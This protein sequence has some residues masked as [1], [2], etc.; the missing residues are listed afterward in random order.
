MSKYEKR[1]V[2]AEVTDRIIA[3]L[4]SGTVPW[5]KPWTGD[6]WQPRNLQSGR[7]YRGINAFLL[8]LAAYDDPRWT[9]FNGAKKLG[10][11]VRKGEKG[12]LVT[13]WKFLKS[14]PTPEN[15]E[16]RTIPM[17]KHFIVFNV[18]QVEW[19]EGAI[20]EY[21]PTV[22]EEFSPEDEAEATMADFLDRPDAPTLTYGGGRAYY[23]PSVHAVNLPNRDTFKSAAGFYGTAFHEFGHATG[24]MLKPKRDLGSGGFGSD[25]YAREELVAE[26]TAAFVLGTLGIDAEHKNSA[27]YI[28]GWLRAIREDQQDGGGKLVIQAA[29]QAQK[30]ADLILGTVYE[31]P[32]SDDTSEATAP[33]VV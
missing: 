26:M 6:Q 25:P 8:S 33:A 24:S 20:P 30:A 13:L 5:Q 17:L 14:K 21:D 16:G 18:A 28:K 22:P 2:Y 29:G 15:P 7:P 3:A 11:S 9:T 10:G 32:K 4:E 1:N 31:E 19:P 23:M 27:A 12:S